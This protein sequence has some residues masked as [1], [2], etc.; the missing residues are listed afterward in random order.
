MDTLEFS[1]DTILKEGWIKLFSYCYNRKDNH[2]F[3]DVYDSGDFISIKDRSFPELR[4]ET[5]L[6]L[7]RK[8]LGKITEIHLSDPHN[9]MILSRRL[10][11][12][13]P[14]DL[15]PVDG[16]DSLAA[17]VPAIL[18]IDDYPY[19]ISREPEIL[20]S[21]RKKESFLHQYTFENIC[22]GIPF[23][24]IFEGGEKFLTYREVEIE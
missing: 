10:G 18:S 12:K 2:P 8:G 13:I 21:S 7:L 22:S 16:S 4:L 23:Q 24:V 11:I 3:L 6:E 19:D 1:R 20:E 9:Y 14:V 5:V 15:R 17:S